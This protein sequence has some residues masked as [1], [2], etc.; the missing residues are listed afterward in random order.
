M[1]KQASTEAVEAKDPTRIVYGTVQ[2]ESPLSILIDQRLSV[3]S[4]FLVLTRNVS[5]YKTN[6]KMSG[7]SGSSSDDNSSDG[8][9]SGDGT[10]EI[11]NSLK[12]GDR[13]ILIQAQGGQEY[14]VLIR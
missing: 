14:I 1:I 13:V 8:G 10:A 2:S 11:D 12:T 6:I 4:D 7:G 9:S 3:S 5:K